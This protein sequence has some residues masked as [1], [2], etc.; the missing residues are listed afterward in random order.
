MVRAHYLAQLY[1]YSNIKNVSPNILIARIV[2]SLFM[3]LKKRH[4]EDISNVGKE[5]KDQTFSLHPRREYHLRKRM[6]REQNL[7]SPSTNSKCKYKDQ[8][9]WKG[10]WWVCVNDPT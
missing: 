4:P 7:C 2:V 10:S 6:G 9:M 5:M 3:D 1:K 8:T